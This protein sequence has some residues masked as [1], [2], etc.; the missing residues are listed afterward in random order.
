MTPYIFLSLLG[1]AVVVGA[2]FAIG[3]F[4]VLKNI[5]RGRAQ[6]TKDRARIV[7]FNKTVEQIVVRQKA[8]FVMSVI[9]LG[10]LLFARTFSH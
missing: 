9:L 8:I 1:S 5:T 10:V 2:G 7:L 6:R 3:G 4:Q